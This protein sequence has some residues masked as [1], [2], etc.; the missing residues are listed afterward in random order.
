MNRHVEV[1][2]IHALIFHVRKAFGKLFSSHRSY[3]AFLL[4]LPKATFSF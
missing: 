4:Q 2:F 1:W 3:T